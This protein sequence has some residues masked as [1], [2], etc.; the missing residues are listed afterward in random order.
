MKYPEKYFCGPGLSRY[1]SKLLERGLKLFND[2]IALKAPITGETGIDG[3]M[4][5]FNCGL[6]LQIPEGNWHVR[7]GVDDVTFFDEDIERVTL[8][9]MEKFFVEWEIALWLDGEPIFYHQFD[10]RGARVHFVF[11]Q[12]PIGDNIAMLPYAEE[13]RRA[14]D[15]EVTC[16]VP[17]AFTAIVENYF[18]TLKLSKA[19]PD[20]AYACY[21]LAGW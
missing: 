7:I 1:P 6:R 5:D 8:I 18:P 10:P 15:C 11:A 9:S 21:Y 19:L 3:V 20:D 4:L 14:F 12:P 2:K 13:F 16:K 17:D